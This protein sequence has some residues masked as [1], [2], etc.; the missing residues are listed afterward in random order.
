MVERHILGVTDMYV[1]I[2]TVASAGDR[3]SG[4]G[5]LE[6]RRRQRRRT[7]PNGVIWAQGTLYE[8]V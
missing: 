4:T 2:N 3:R 5:L 6:Q 7:E 1:D 8:W